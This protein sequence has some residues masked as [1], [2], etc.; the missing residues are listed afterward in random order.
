MRVTRCFAFLDLCGFTMFTAEQGDDQASSVLSVLRTATR[1]ATE[2]R[3][4][5][6]VKWLGDGVMLSSIETE[7]LVS[8]TL[9][10]MNEVSRLGHLPVRAGIVR[11]KVI[12][13]EG[14]DYIG[15]AVNL[16]SRMCDRAQ[17]GQLL[18]ANLDHQRIPWFAEYATLDWLDGL[19]LNQEQPVEVVQLE[20]AGGALT[21]PVCGLP[22]DPNRMPESQQDPSIPAFCSQ[23]CRSHWL[24]EKTGQSL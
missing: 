8:C 14:E 6:L 2:R 13:F 1:T 23:P 7:P 19:V 21:D 17:P 10:I 4:I 16:A 15:S 3:G 5:R 11:G 20:L 12:M 18:A 24:S 9:E 22:L